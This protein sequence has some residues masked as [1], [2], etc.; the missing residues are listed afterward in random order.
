METHPIEFRRLGEEGL[1]IE[2][3]DGFNQKLPSEMLRRACPCAACR[4]A[5][6][7]ISHE[8]PLG[9]EKK[10]ALQIIEHTIAEETRLLKIW[11]VGTYAIGLSWGD[12]H[13]TGIYTYQYLRKLSSS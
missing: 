5:R 6:G 3:S 2:W 13:N 8:K 1:A 12:G 10:R 4:E 7:E 9:S 11:S